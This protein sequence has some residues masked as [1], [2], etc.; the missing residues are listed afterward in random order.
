MHP[1]ILE[2]LHADRHDETIMYIFATLLCTSLKSETEIKE[3]WQY[4]YRRKEDHFKPEITCHKCSTD[5]GETAKSK[6][7]EH[8]WN[9]DHLIQWYKVEITHKEEA[10]H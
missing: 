3:S 10:D 1:A 8:T 4:K 9:E 5:M 7:S 6:I 2:L